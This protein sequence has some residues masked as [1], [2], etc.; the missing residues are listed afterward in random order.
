MQ[1]ALQRL[2][3]PANAPFVTVV[4]DDA[5]SAG[6]VRHWLEADGFCVNV[7]GCAESLLE[8]LATTIPDVIVLDLGLP[9]VR[10]VEALTRIAAQSRGIP[11]VVH[12]AER[13]IRTVVAAMREGAFDFVEK[14]AKRASL[15]DAARRASAS[16]S[17]PF[18]T[19]AQW[20]D[21]LQSS[22]AAAAD[23]ESLQ[24]LATTQVPLLLLGSDAGQRATLA[25]T[26]HEGSLASHQPFETVSAPSLRT[27]AA[28]AELRRRLLATDAR[29]ADLDRPGTLFID[30]L[31]QLDAEAQS[32][33][34]QSLRGGPRQGPARP[35]IIAGSGPELCARVRARRVRADLYYALSSFE[36]TLESLGG[37]PERVRALLATTLRAAP[38]CATISEDALEV[39]CRY[40]WP[41]DRTEFDG[42]L[43]R[44]LHGCTGSGIT[45]A[46]LPPALQR[47][48]SATGSP[49]AP[50]RDRTLAELEREAI[51]ETLAR[52]RGNIS[53]TCR[54]L[55]IGR[56]T[57]YRKLER[58]GLR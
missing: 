36:F 15:V 12:S 19:H 1:S 56:T 20:R 35:R 9:G 2:R 26:L 58:Y 32:L 25:R 5:T 24:R 34:A 52:H 46:D 27:P 7:L 40:A 44:A 10:G 54:V 4:E 57:L 39:L 33:L 30:D 50:A 47:R 38:T 11:I 42:V 28:R 18:H 29:L 45:L 22:G 41:G 49:S 51:R 6:M 23:V 31:D 17:A 21:L 13:D 8:G 43:Q 3:P 16:V 48:R 55:G 53:A 14:P 37:N